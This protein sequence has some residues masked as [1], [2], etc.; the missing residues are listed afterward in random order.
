MSVLDCSRPTLNIDS[1]F[2][3][4]DTQIVLFSIVFAIAH[5]LLRP[6]QKV[7]DNAE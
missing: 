4:V 7:I 2:V 5:G 6:W 1:D 3:L